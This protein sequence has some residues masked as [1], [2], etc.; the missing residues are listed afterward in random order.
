MRSRCAVPH[1]I[2]GMRFLSTVVVL[3]FSASY[4]SP[5]AQQPP[6]FDVVIRGGTVYDGT[7][8]AGKQAD[9]AIRGDRIAAVGDLTGA[10]AST[11]VDAKGLVVAPGFINMLSWATESLLVDGRSQGDIR[12]GVT[13]EIFGEGSSMGPLKIGRASCRE[14]GESA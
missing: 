1:I 6:T 2:R 9:V 12:H 5:T 3:A 8:S 10:S 13:T 14:G 7:G 4:I 11:I